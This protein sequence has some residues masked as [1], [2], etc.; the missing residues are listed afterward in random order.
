MRSSAVCPVVF[1]VPSMESTKISSQAA[2]GLEVHAQLQTAT[3]MF[4]AC[5]NTFGAAPNSQTCPVCLGL[6]G[7]LP[8]VNGRAVELAVTAALAANCTLNK[9]SRFTRKHYFYPD[10]PR[11]YQI[12]QFDRPLAEC[13]FIEFE[14]EDGR[15][16][17]VGISRI[18]L[19]DDAGK[20][21]HERGYSLVD[22]NRAGVP[23]IE[24]VTEPVITSAADAAAFLRAL[25]TLLQYCGV[26][27]GNMQEGAFRCD[28]NVSIVHEDHCGGGTRVELKNLNSFRH[29]KRAVSHEIERQQSCLDGAQ[30]VVAETRLWDDCTRETRIMRSK[31]ESPDYLYCPDPDLGILRISE[32]LIARARE[33]LP[34]LPLKKRSRFIR[35][36]GLSSASADILIRCVQTARYFEKTVALGADPEQAAKWIVRDI[37]HALQDP[38]SIET[39]SVSPFHLARLLSMLQAGRL[40]VKN[41]KAVFDTIVTTSR[42][43]DD[44]IQ[45]YDVYP[46]LNPDETETVVNDVCLRYPVEAQRYRD[47]KTRLLGFFVGRVMEATEHRAHP[48]LVNKL[49]RRK[50]DG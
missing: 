28:A 49:V 8:V 39:F 38:R 17:Q 7:S 33:S 1:R 41:A 42:F 22:Y 47:G 13:G 31:E 3:K 21:R 45:S 35:D 10:L 15:V 36:Y 4:C 12:T 14:T 23:L 5:P 16:Q 29:V 25:Q 6:P 11:G 20:L 46:Y 19:E 32:E 48:V 37:L 18:H 27:D 26:C 40:S 30:P 44:I 9:N 2:I 34:E 43:P 50:L 24:I